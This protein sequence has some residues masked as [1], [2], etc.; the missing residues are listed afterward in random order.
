MMLEENGNTLVVLPGPPREMRPMFENHVVPV[1]REHAGGVVARKRLLRVAGIGESAVDEKISP[2]YKAYPNVETSILFSKVEIEVHLTARADSQENAEAVLD[3]LV[4]RIGDALG[5]AL[6]SRD[7][8]TMEEVVGELLRERGMTVSLAES[9]TGGL[10]AMRLTEVAG[11][12]EYFLEGVVTYSNEAKVR[13]LG[14]T[15]E[16][17]ESHGAVSS[18]TAEAMARGIRTASG[19]DVAVSVT[20]IAGPGGGSEDKPVGTVYVGFSD[21]NGDRSLKVVLP[22]DRYLIRWR[23]S[24][25]ALDY[26]RRQ[27]L[28]RG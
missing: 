26:L 9:C 10:I 21:E 7:A 24:Q 20:G 12:S 22:G 28:K 2:V 4:E 11:S 23:S 25:A 15:K 8:K 13:Q 17:I 19:S 18:Q 14:V 3:E 6:F 1:L 27:L 5:P 16:T